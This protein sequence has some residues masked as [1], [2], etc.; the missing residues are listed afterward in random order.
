MANIV[1]CK[2]CKAK[3]R[4]K[5][6][7]QG[8]VPVCGRCSAAL[9]WLVNAT[10]SSFKQELRSAVPVLVDFWAAWCGPCRMIAP[11]LEGISSDLAGQLKI[12]K[13]NVD[14]NPLTS[15]EYRVQSIPLLILFKNGD[16]V[17]TF[18]GA[19]PK[20]TMMQRLKPHL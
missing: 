6:S 7:P 19:L 12:I 15:G 4:L 18:V 10:D 16:E 9:P 14:E 2:A 13:L 8:Q 20:A 17:D 5:V 3:N 1:S 11:V